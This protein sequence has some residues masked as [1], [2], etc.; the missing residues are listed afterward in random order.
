MGEVHKLSCISPD[1]CISDDAS[2][3]IQKA[4]LVF[5]NRK[6]FRLRCDIRVSIKGRIY[7]LALSSILSYSSE[8]WSLTAEDPQTFLVLV[9]HCLCN[10]GRIRKRNFFSYS[11]VRRKLLDHRVHTLEHA[12]NQN[13]CMRLDCTCSQNDY[14]VHGSARQ[15]MVVRRV[16]V[17][18]Q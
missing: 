13:R 6:Y 14:L 4:H 12:L 7:S 11:M 17:A 1:N 8:T 5:T 10:I 18:S 15:V 16:Q 2:S 3:D 9:H